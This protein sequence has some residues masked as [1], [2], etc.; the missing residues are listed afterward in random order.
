VRR[1]VLAVRAAVRVK[2][3]T[4]IPSINCRHAEALISA[5]DGSLRKLMS[6]SPQALERVPVSLRQKLGTER[7]LAVKRALDC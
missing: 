6:A 4:A 7:A 5:Y 3:L 2:M 1:A